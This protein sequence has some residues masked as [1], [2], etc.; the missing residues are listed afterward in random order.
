MLRCL[1][2]REGEEEASVGAHT[3]LVCPV[4]RSLTSE[5]FEPKRLYFLLCLFVA[6]VVV[7]VLNEMNNIVDCE[8]AC[9]P[10]LDA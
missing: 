5:S 2:E 9:E 1:C 3:G 8:H 4:L 7:V 10:R 6:R